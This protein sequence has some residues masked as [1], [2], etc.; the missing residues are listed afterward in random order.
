LGYYA[1]V[2][3]PSAKE[4]AVKELQRRRNS[5]KRSLLGAA[6]LLA[7]LMGVAELSRSAAESGAEALWPGAFRLV[8]S[9]DLPDGSWETTAEARPSRGC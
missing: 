2:L 5:V 6:C 7:C 1:R 3:S 4:I 9:H 8:D